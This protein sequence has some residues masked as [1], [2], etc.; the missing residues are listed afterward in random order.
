MPAYK[1]NQP[2]RNIPEPGSPRHT[3]AW[4]LIEAARRLAVTIEGTDDDSIEVKAQRRDALRLNWRLWTIFQA[5]LLE[6]TEFPEELR[7]N[8]LTLCQF[9]DN[10]TV[11]TLVEPTPEKMTVFIDINRNVASGLLGSPDEA[12]QAT[13][14]AQPAAEPEAP[15]PGERIRIEESV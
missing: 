7:V 14:Q 2:Y 4:A 3:E 13:S 12:T 11:Q 8:L 6:E 5:S 9:I 1:P 15:P 10:Q